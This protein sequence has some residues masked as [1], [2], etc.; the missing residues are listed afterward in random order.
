M[1]FGKINTNILLLL[2]VNNEYAVSYDG[3]NFIVHRALKGYL[4][5]VFMPHPS[6][7]HVYNLQ[8]LR[9]LA[10]YAFIETVEESM[11]MFTINK[12]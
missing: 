1:V 12:S 7:L 3:E 8:D 10:S 2:Q 4:Y 6:G 9:G 5:M 11:A